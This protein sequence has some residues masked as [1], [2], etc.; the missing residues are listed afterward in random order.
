[1]LLIAIR[2]PV[3][4][5]NA[6]CE[7]KN[8]DGGVEKRLGLSSTRKKSENPN[9]DQVYESSCSWGWKNL[10]LVYFFLPQLRRE[11]IASVEGE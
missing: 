2:G 6:P 1:M 4:A 7:Q 11:S 3:N 5:L 9:I 8:E 10:F